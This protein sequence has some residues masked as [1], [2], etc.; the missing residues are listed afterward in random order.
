LYSYWERGEGVPQSQHLHIISEVT[1]IEVA[2][3]LRMMQEFVTPH[4]QKK[5]SEK[6]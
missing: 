2:E 5:M 4:M 6:K 3:L 1:K